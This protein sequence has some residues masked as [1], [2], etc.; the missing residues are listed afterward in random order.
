M[1]DE[2]LE[3][4][5][6]KIDL[7]EADVLLVMR[8]LTQLQPEHNGESIQ[9]WTAHR[10]DWRSSCRLGQRERGEPRRGSNRH[11][12]RSGVSSWPPRNHPEE[13]PR[14]PIPGAFLFSVCAA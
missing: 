3:G 6:L 8:A 4:T 2:W 10:N 13:G 7:T 14:S 11:R 12:Y 5:E 9:R 1:N